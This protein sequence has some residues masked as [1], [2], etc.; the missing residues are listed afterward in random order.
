M[1]SEE[2]RPLPLGRGWRCSTC[3]GLIR[4]VDDGWVEWLAGLDDQGI[5]LLEGLR[6]VHS[7][8]ASPRT[9]EQYGCEYNAA[10][11]FHTRR[12]LV[13]GLPLERFVGADGLMLLLSL[14][15]E[16]E[17]PRSDLLELAKRVQI[18]GYELTREFFHEAIASGVLAPAIADG[19]YLQ[20]E[21]WALFNWVSEEAKSA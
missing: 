9:G 17:M 21:M 7:R 5:T 15:A 8:S 13:E 14:I 2:N 12:N 18:P 19:Y 1:S 16:D 3:G 20:S 4:K 11:E 6:L 10:Q